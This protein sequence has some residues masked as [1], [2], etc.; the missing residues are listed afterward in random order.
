MSAAATTMAAEAD[1]AT[2]AAATASSS[3]AAAAGAAAAAPDCYMLLANVT[4][5]SNI[6]PLI[7]SCVAF[8]VKEMCVVGGGKLA[9]F[10]AHGSDKYMR[11]STYG[12]IRPAVEDLKKKGVTICGIEITKD[13]VPVHEHPFR[14][15]TAFLAGA[16]GNGMHDSHKA[17][18]DHF[19]YIPQ[20]GNGTASLNVGVAISIVLHHFA[21]WAGYK[22]RPREVRT[23]LMA[24]GAWRL[25]HAAPPP[26]V[27]F[28]LSAQAD[29]DKFVVEKPVKDG[30]E[31]TL[32]EHDLQLR[33]E[34]AKKRAEREAA[35]AAAAAAI[36]GVV[37]GAAA[38]GAAAGS[39]DDDDDDDGG[40]DDDDGSD[41][42]DDADGGV[43]K[44]PASKR[45]RV[46]NGGDA[47]EGAAATAA[48][49][50]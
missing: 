3:A 19:V 17:L 27:Y 39:A 24:A 6:G 13:A 43:A 9:T 2:S 49:S 28:C 44:P 1:A 5:K 14:G 34:R 48:A 15:P 4:K 29:C 22:E 20:V 36:G 38:G 7:R 16:E 18:C 30:T 50:V 37:A 31:A 35:A 11:V 42:G 10:G 26:G 12:N 23:R 47:G 25:Q 33:A 45:A 46:D 32:T 41:A 21:L 8:G 40:G